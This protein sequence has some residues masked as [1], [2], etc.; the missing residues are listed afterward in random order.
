MMKIDRYLIV[1]KKRNHQPSARITVTAPALESHEIAIKISLDVPEAL[2]SK[3]Q[4]EASITIPSA[5][6]AAP[7]IEAAVI[8]NIKEIVAKELGV[9]L[10]IGL[11]DSQNHINQGE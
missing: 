11:V 3:P 9:D 2:F 6:I 8:D 7:V 10:S 5:S 1:G 4:L